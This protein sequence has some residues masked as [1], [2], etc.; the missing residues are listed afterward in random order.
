MLRHSKPF[1]AVGDASRRT[2]SCANRLFFLVEIGIGGVDELTIDKEEWERPDPSHFTGQKYYTNRHFNDLAPSLVNH[3]A[4]SIKTV[5]VSA[6]ECGSLTVIIGDARRSHDI[7]MNKPYDSA[8]G[9][10]LE[11]VQAVLICGCR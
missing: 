8:S 11:F 6:H 4:Y 3:L 2:G 5:R 10:K 7:L 1:G 9:H